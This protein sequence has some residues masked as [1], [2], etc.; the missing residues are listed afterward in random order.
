MPMT[1][2]AHHALGDTSKEYC[3]HCAKEDGSMLSYEEVLE[4]SVPWGM[5]NFTLMGFEKQP[6]EAEM[7]KALVAHM[8]TLP[9][10]KN[11]K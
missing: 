10:W 7:R 6:T 3:L 1:E 4:G 2:A 8:A 9:A 5:E 11:K